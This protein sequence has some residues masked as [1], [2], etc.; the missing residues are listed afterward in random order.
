MSSP[1]P[2]TLFE[3]TATDIVCEPEQQTDMWSPAIF[4]SL[5]ALDW[6]GTST[7]TSAD[8]SQTVVSMESFRQHVFRVHKLEE[9]LRGVAEFVLTIRP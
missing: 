8:M 2:S 4:T 3:Q 5:P 1:S 9:Q 6:S 7:S